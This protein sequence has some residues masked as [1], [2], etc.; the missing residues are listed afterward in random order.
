M[1]AV[2]TSRDIF[3]RLRDHREAIRS[4]GVGRLGVFG[5]FTRN[6]Q[7]SDSD[8]DILVEFEKGEKSFDHF[9]GLA[10]L[11]ED[12]LQRRVELV[13]VESLSP[14]LGPRILAE[15]QDVPLGI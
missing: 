7:H 11:L 4:L 1:A 15:V 3:S 10:F 6:E 5:S 13:T 9:M 12:I 8:V 14:H 2:K